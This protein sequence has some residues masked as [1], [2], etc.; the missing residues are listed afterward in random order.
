MADKAVENQVAGNVSVVDDDD[1]DTLVEESGQPIEFN[2]VGDKFVGTYSGSKLI[3]P[4]G[5][6]EKDFFTQHKFIDT[7]GEMRVING[8]HKL[9]EA[10]KNDLKPGMKVRIT[11]MPD[12]KIK[13]QP[14]PMKDYKIEVAKS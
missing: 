9:N 14:S 6:D 2:A 11:R 7:D 3:Q 5:W 4:E 8:G 13:D 12:V 10:A 1:W